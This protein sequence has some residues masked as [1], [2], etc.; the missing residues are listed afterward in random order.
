MA[1][2]TITMKDGSTREFPHEG[3]GGGSYSKSVRYE[4]GFVIV[5]DEWGKETAIPSS[6]VKEVVKKPE[7]YGW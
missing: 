7:R 6:D 2:I 1:S 3:R 4:G 5:T